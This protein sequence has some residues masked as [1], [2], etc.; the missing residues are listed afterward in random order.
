VHNNYYFLRQLSKSLETTLTGTVISECFSQNKD[1]LVIR[2]ETHTEPF[3][4]KASLDPSFTCL[5]F[6]GDFSRARKNSVDLFGDMIGHRVAGIRQFENERSFAIL[7]SD[8]K[9]LLFKM[10]GNRSN[11]I[12]FEKDIPAQLFRNNIPADITLRLNALDRT[13]DW[14]Y[15]SF[16]QHRTKLQSLYFT[17]G[18]IIWK[19][20][21]TKNFEALSPEQQWQ[22]IQTIK[23]QLE[24]PVYF[25]SQADNILALSLIQYGHTLKEFR[26]PVKA[27]NEFFY[28]YTQ[29]AAFIREKASTL[30]LLRNKL[31]GSEAYYQKTFDKLTEVES[32][33]H[34]KVWADL[35]MAYMHEI[36]PGTEKVTL[37]DF[38][39]EN[40]P[41]EI[42]LKKDIPPQKNAEVFYRKAKNQH[43][44]IQRLQEVLEAKE[45]EI[46]NL[47]QQL[48]EFE[49]IGELKTLRKTISSKGLSDEKEKQSAPLPFHEFEMSGFKIWVGR[50]AQNN[51][52][53]TFKYGFKEDLWLHAKD[54]AGSHVLIK[55]QSGKNYPKDVIERAAQLAAYNSKRK[56]ETLCPV[57]VTPK[58][59][60]RKRKGDPAGAVV[61]ER[62]EVI[63]V[64]PPKQL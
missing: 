20:L 58:K 63:L 17:F 25:I 1:E 64:E 31:Q 33:N 34:Y 52:I 49:T 39:H 7:L 45:K 30:S 59:F 14:S 38:Y 18:K 21:A 50:N 12:L 62:E 46:E 3:F 51:D 6:P 55:Y 37:P 28:T 13:I 11:I 10:H 26:D 44:E 4:I 48:H 29:Q 36:K 27:T 16:L 42:K 9:S 41:V 35:V 15:E 56:T 32:D 22:E 19:S 53:L 40:K 61:V 47:K 60:V 24:T 54:V 23:Q 5:S 8:D 2:F 57:I 43:I